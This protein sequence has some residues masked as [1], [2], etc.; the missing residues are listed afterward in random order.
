MKFM[1]YHKPV[2]IWYFCGF[3][4]LKILVVLL[5]VHFLRII[6]SGHL[7]KKKLR[8]LIKAQCRQG[9]SHVPV[10]EVIFSTVDKPKLLSQVSWTVYYLFF[11]FFL[12]FY[13]YYCLV[14]ESFK[15]PNLISQA[16]SLVA[17]S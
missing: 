12:F 11:I 17:C 10:H 14:Y 13:F 9:I 15:K 8:C 5:R 16:C 3:I 2:R 4:M 1:I 6:I 7:C